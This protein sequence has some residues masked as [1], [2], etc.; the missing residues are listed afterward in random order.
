MSAVALHIEQ[1]LL[2]QFVPSVPRIPQPYAQNH[3]N[4]WPTEL[5]LDQKVVRFVTLIFM[6]T[7]K[8][9]WTH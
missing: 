3:I 4:A 1:L 5:R 2:E 6:M 7:L 8:M 9:Q